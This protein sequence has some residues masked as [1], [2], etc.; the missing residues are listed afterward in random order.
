[1]EVSLI[2]HTPDPDRTVA[3]G[4]RLCYSSSNVD[5][6]YNDMDEQEVKKLINMLKKVGHTSPIEHISF[7][8]GIEG[9][10][11][12][13]SHQLVRH[14]I[15]SYTQKSQ[16]YVSEEG[17]CYITPPTIN[18]SDEAKKIYEE[19]M[20]MLQE[21]YNKLCE[22][23]PK[24]DARYI[25]PNSCET[26]LVATFNARSLINF[27]QLR[28]CFRAQWE[29]RE[30]AWRMLEKVKEVS[31][32]VFEDVGA[33]CDMTKRCTEGKKSCGRYKILVEKD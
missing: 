30:L 6:I 3:A 10:S 12:A 24:E 16:R 1:M 7:T 29:I 25:L 5:E 17:F 27:F 23:V 2:K 18:E 26:K 9:I 15:A 8:F 11:R 13:L 4:A 31:P 22:K 14:R 28:C 33:E 32:Y 20:Q 19:T 21:N